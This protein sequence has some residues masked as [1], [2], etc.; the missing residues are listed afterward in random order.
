MNPISS[1]VVLASSTEDTVLAWIGGLFIAFIVLVLEWV[2]I[3][4]VA[5]GCIFLFRTP[6]P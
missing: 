6:K 4:A 2:A 5:G 1:S 3:A